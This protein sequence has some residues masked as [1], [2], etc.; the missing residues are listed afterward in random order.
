VT[1]QTWVGPVGWRASIHLLHTAPCAVEK[2]P[3]TVALGQP[4]ASNRQLLPVRA[5]Q[6]FS[7][8]FK[9]LMRDVRLD[10]ERHGNVERA[11][12]ARTPQ[13]EGI[14]SQTELVYQPYTPVYL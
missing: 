8:L 6:D 2:Q 5:K 7:V 9:V 14:R 11:L 10:P 12:F 1:P 13:R 3:T 4:W